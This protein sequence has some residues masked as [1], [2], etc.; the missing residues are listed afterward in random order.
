MCCVVTVF[1]GAL[2]LASTGWVG[3]FASALFGVTTLFCQ[4]VG[5]QQDMH[6][7]HKV[8]Q[9]L[10]HQRPGVAYECCLSPTNL[11]GVK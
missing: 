1:Q 7:H 6:L 11:H 8:D 9:S 3:L 2:Y 4:P 5:F 10:L